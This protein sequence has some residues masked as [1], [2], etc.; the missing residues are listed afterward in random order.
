MSLRERIVD[1][2]QTIANN[3]LAEKPSNDQDNEGVTLSGPVPELKLRTGATFRTRKV[4]G[5]YDLPLTSTS[6]EI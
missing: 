2:L 3:T 4:A 6:D 5:R 1:K